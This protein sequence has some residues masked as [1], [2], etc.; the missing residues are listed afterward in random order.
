M[1]VG[2]MEH[3]LFITKQRKALK[4][5]SAVFVF[6]RKPVFTNPTSTI[7]DVELIISLRKSYILWMNGMNRG[8]YCH[9]KG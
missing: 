3:P 9:I 8:R 2:F 1:T 4:W 7:V 6:K 5:F